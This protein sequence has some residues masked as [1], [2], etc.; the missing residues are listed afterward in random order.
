MDLTVLI[1]GHMVHLGLK[2]TKVKVTFF[3]SKLMLKPNYFHEPPADTKG[4]SGIFVASL[5]I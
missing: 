1:K 2:E 5:S 3:I 4:T